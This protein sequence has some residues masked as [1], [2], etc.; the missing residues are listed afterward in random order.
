M[1]LSSLVS[2]T[3]SVSTGI[4][5]SALSIWR[6]TLQLAGRSSVGNARLA[7][8]VEASP[9]APRCASAASRFGS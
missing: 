4:F 2:V 1:F 5:L 6:L 3:R 7:A 8:A 9:S